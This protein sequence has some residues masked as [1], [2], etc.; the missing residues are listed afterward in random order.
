MHAKYYFCFAN[1]SLLSFS[2]SLL[3]RII[4]LFEIR[5]LTANYQAGIKLNMDRNRMLYGHSFLN[6]S[7]ITM[8]N[9]LE[10]C[11]K[12]C[13]CLSF[14]I[15]DDTTKCQLC[16]S[17]KY[18]K[19]HAMQASQGCINYDLGRQEDTRVSLKMIVSIPFYVLK[20]IFS[21]FLNLF[22]R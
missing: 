11:V 6:L 12:N 20:Y 15:C 14:Q 8:E 22:S 21:L 5:H 17:N 13:L 1:I 7:G 3:V 16:S 18:L 10:H 2:L 9:C 19:P 4:I